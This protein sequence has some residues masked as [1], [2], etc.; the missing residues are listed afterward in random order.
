[1]E[2]K[3]KLYNL[4]AS[5]AYFFRQTIFYLSISSGYFLAGNLDVFYLLSPIYVIKKIKKK[6][7][8][9]ESIIFILL[10]LAYLM[11]QIVLIRNLNII[12]AT[13]NM[14]KIIFCYFVMKYIKENY[15]KLNF[16]YICKVFSILCMIFLIISIIFPNSILWRHNDTINKYDLNRLQFLYTEPS[17]LGLHA[18]IIFILYSFIIINIKDAKKKIYYIVLAV[19]III[20]LLLAKPL[21]A[22]GIGAIS[23]ATLCITDLIFNFSKKKLNIYIVLLLFIVTIIGGLVIT[24]NSLYLRIVDT[25]N[26]QDSSN[27]YRITVPFK[28]SKQILLDT[29]GIGIGFGNAELS[30]NVDR[31]KELGLQEEGIINSY[32]NLISESGIFGIIII[33][34]IIVQLIKKSIKDKSAVK[35]SLSAFIILYQFMGTY[36]TNPLCWIIYGIILSDIDF[37][38]ICK[39]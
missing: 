26:G 12:R 36:F 21:G 34:I 38:K 24:R 14:A 29:Y 28:V 32:L 20:A 5:I 31:Y 3:D 15:Y 6:K 10:C 18:M 27:S 4:L 22:I 33:S 7:V 30:K 23:I 37:K 25:L 8:E 19:P 13:I 16:Q 39:Q 9:E 1:M 11:I 35:L 17:E 2:K